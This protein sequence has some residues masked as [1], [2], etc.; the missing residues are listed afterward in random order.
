MEIDF[1]EGQPVM[2]ELALKLAIIIFIPLLAAFIVM[3]LLKVCRIPVV[4][5]RY[6]GVG[7]FLF[8]VYQMFV[9]LY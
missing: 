5:I 4:L 9:I 6:I 7:V 2:N 8:G 3:F 1:S